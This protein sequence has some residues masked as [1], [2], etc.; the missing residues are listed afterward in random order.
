MQLT[1]AATLD[2][3][4]GGAE[5]SAVQRPFVEMFFDSFSP[6]LFMDNKNLVSRNR[7]QSLHH[8]TRP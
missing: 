2:R 8:I 4:S 6:R 1:E 5:G 3:K 7:L